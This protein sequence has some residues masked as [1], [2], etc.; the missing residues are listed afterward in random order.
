MNAL[1]DESLVG[2]MLL[3]SLLYAFAKLA[4]RNA[5]SRMLALLGAILQRAPAALRL[6]PMAQ[7]LA[8]AADDKA[9]SACGGCDTCGSD[10]R[11]PAAQTEISVP[12]ASIG[13]ARPSR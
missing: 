1:L 10:V 11:A 9:Q 6:R 7:R 4:P 5:R 2:L 3:M 13:R 12:I 8:R